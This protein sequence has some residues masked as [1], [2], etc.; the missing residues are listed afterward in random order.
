MHECRWNKLSRFAHLL[1][2]TLTLSR[3]HRCIYI[4]RL[5]VIRRLRWT[6]IKIFTVQKLLWFIDKARYTDSTQH[7]LRLIFLILCNVYTFEKSNHFVKLFIAWNMM[8]WDLFTARVQ[9]KNLTKIFVVK[10]N[11]GTSRKTCNFIFFTI[12]T[13]RGK[14]ETGLVSYDPVLLPY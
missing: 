10:K 9:C 13:S 1:Q 5:L 14:M 3:W 8:F 11:N 2:F 6:K 4:M 7:L 12:Q